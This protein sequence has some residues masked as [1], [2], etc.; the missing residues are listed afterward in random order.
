MVPS[1]GARVNQPP[2]RVGSSWAL[3]GCLFG[4]VALF[5]ILLIVMIFLA[6]QRFREETGG[7]PASPAARIERL[8]PSVLGWHLQSNASSVSLGD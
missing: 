7:D 2:T 4:S 3:Q 1:Y 8:E 5:V 6:A